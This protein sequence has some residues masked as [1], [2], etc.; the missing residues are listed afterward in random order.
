MSR[1][2][3]LSIPLL[4]VSLVAH[5]QEA[6]A[7][8]PPPPPPEVAE[9]S[10]AEPPLITLGAAEGSTPA[11]AAR[12]STHPAAELPREGPSASTLPRSSR[13][14]AQGLGGALGAVLGGSIALAFAFVPESSSV[15]Q[16]ITGPVAIIGALGAPILGVYLVGSLLGGTGALLGT[17][18]GGLV[19]TAAGYGFAMIAILAGAVMGYP[20]YQP[21]IIA[22]WAFAA[23]SAFALPV[24]GSLIGYALSEGTPIKP[25]RLEKPF[26]NAA[27]VPVKGGAVLSL[28]GQM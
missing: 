8:P 25:S 10:P 1:A 13:L 22:G 21:A 24:A 14:L 11:E 15:P 26:V 18:L 4:V 6:E 12:V 28:S 7:P 19:G 20:N 3:V 17:A 23:V 5:A 2:S 27:V 9:A 16:M